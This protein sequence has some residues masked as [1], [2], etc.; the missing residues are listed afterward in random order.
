MGWSLPWVHNTRLSCWPWRITRPR[1]EGATWQGSVG[2]FQEPD[3]PPLTVHKR[4]GT[5]GLQLQERNAVWVG[6]RASRR[7]AAPLT[8]WLLVSSLLQ[9]QQWTTSSTHVF[10]KGMLYKMDF[11]NKYCQIAFHSCTNLYSH[12]DQP[13]SRSL[14]PRPFIST[15]Y[16]HISGY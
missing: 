11:A 10:R 4:M 8:P 6:P 3:S 14:V 7:T 2:P 12:H 9:T 5:S 13:C 16:E 15:G 1:W